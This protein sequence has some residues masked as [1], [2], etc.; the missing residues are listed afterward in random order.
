M[1]STVFW[2]FVSRWM[3]HQFSNPPNKHSEPLIEM[4]WGG[5]AVLAFALFHSRGS[6]A[7]LLVQHSGC[8]ERLRPVGLN[9]DELTMDVCLTLELARST[10]SDKVATRLERSIGTGNIVH[11]LDITSILRCNPEILCEQNWAKTG[12]NNPSH[13]K[14]LYLVNQFTLFWCAPLLNSRAHVK[15]V[16]LSSV[17]SYW[18]FV[19]HNLG[20]ELPVKPFVHTNIIYS[21]TFQCSCR[22]IYSAFYQTE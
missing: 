4:A 7:L 17:L 14:I 2:E 15:I 3:A 19:S 10:R 22:A 11:S 6:N 18:P 20:S 13:S 12:I 1:Y 16:E 8:Y 5:Q 21:N 9:I